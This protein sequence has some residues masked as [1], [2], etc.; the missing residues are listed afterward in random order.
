ML[1]QS[2][3]LKNPDDTLAAV[4]TLAT[5]V[6]AASSADLATV[7]ASAATTLDTAVSASIDEAVTAAAATETTVSNEGYSIPQS[8]SVLETLE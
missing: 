2:S 7:I 6:A 8:I 1:Q 3:W 5:T 4:E